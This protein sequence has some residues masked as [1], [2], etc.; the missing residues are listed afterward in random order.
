MTD[1]SFTGRKRIR[2]SYGRIP[3]VAPMPNLIEVQKNSYEAF[4]QRDIA[5]SERTDTGLQEVFKSVFPIKDFSERGTIEFVDYEFETPKYD[6]EEC[7]QRGMTYAA[8][9][10]VTLR[11]VVWDIDEDTEARSVRDIKEQ[12]V[13]MGELPL[14]TGNGT[15][16]VNGTERVIVSQMHRSPGVFFDH[17]KGKTHSSG[18]FLFAARVIPYR[19][20]WL[21][22]EFDAKDIVYVRIDRRRK[23]PVTTML[24]GL[25]SAATAAKRSKLKGAGQSINPHEAE[26]M[27]PEEILKYFYETINYERVKK[28]WQVPLDADSLRGLKLDYDLLNAK[29]GRVAVAAGT[30]FTPRILRDLDKKGVTEYIVPVEDILGRFSSEDIINQE[31]GLIYLEAGD[32]IT[33][34]ILEELEQANIV[35]IPTLAIDHVNVGPYIR[36]TLAVDK[37]TSREDALIDIY[38]VMRPGEPPIIETADSMFQGLFFDPDRYDLSSVGRVKMN[39]RLGQDTEDDV[40]VLRSEDVLEVVKILV[41]LKN[42]K[43]EIDDIDHLGNRRVRSVGEL[44]ENQ[45]RVG[46]LRME[47]AIRERMSTVDIDT[48]MPHDLINAKPASAAVRA[49]RAPALVWLGRL[50][51]VRRPVS[52][53]CH[54]DQHGRQESGAAGQGSRVD[55]GRVDR[56]N[57]QRLDLA[58]PDLLHPRPGQGLR[59]GGGS[60]QGVER[61]RSTIRRDIAGVEGH[62]GGVRKKQEVHVP[63]GRRP[64]R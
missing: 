41:D 53:R 36:N 37:N 50:R 54:A 20:S 44:M 27:S 23:L 47:R 10:K 29:T 14:M 45:Y 35:N 9:L 26:G 30:K 49:I 5:K 61:R 25:D 8:P 7:Q 16:V 15:F 12:V 17:D 28:G 56:Q 57:R 40:R 3:T 55:P 4:L 31:T 13:Y 1:R 33:S 24:L 62:G 48:V 32:E 21:D 51:R 46:L 43:G 60:A 6:V 22:F 52:H 11:L 19:G 34:E 42:G 39:S 38:R 59:E 18:K 58:G 2:K 63:C 64:Q